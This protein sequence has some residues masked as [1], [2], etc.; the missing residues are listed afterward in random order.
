ME[1]QTAKTPLEDLRSDALKHYN[2]AGSAIFTHSS[3][4]PKAIN[5]YYDALENEGPI[6]RLLKMMYEHRKFIKGKFKGNTW[7][8]DEERSEAKEMDKELTTVIMLLETH[9]KLHG[10]KED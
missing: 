9:N 8:N 1:N 4:I 6:D 5:F 2:E 7:M 10:Y 3:E